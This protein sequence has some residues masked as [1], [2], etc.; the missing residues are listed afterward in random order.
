[1]IDGAE[2]ICEAALAKWYLDTYKLGELTRQ[3]Y[4][5]EWNDKKAR[6]RPLAN[7]LKQ[8]VK[9]AVNG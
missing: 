7:I 5:K 2:Q 9:G 1:M 4:I 8:I 3:S 6:I